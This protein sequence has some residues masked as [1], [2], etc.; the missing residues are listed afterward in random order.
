MA[1]NLWRV[2]SVTFDDAVAVVNH[3]RPELQ[4]TPPPSNDAHLESATPETTN[5]ATP[6][7]QPEEESTASVQA[8]VVDGDI[9]SPQ[10][11][12]T[13]AETRMSRETTQTPNEEHN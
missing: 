5:D 12:E 6:T 9:S 2:G 8:L 11:T 3:L 13:E 7:S 1:S 10:A 4:R